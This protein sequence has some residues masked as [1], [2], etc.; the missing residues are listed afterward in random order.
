M[1]LFLF[2]MSGWLYEMYSKMTD[3]DYTGNFKFVYQIKNMDENRA[4]RQ[5]Q[6]KQIIKSQQ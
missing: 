6:Q 1:L 2:A 3:L 4:Q 5:T